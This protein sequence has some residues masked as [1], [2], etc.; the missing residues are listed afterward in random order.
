VL[1]EELDVRFADKQKQIEETR[2][3]LPGIYEEIENIKQ[4]MIDEK[5]RLVESAKES[6][7]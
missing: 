3:K 2:D 7:M 6:M 4:R 5:E 1:R